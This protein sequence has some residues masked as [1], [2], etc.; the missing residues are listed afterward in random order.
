MILS[1]CLGTSI[2]FCHN[3]NIYGL[4]K[5]NI[6]SGYCMCVHGRLECADEKHWD[7]YSCYMVIKSLVKV[8]F[9]GWY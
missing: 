2:N 9:V 4:Q 3:K 6:N 5:R 1:G 7:N 8:K